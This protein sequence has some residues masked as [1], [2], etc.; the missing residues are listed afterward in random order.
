MLDQSTRTATEPPASVSAA[1]NG[2]VILP[3]G[4]LQTARAT[5]KVAVAG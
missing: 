4:T 1:A 5:F 2:A 3:S